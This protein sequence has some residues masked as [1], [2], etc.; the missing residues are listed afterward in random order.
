MLGK[1]NSILVGSVGRFVEVIGGFMEAIGGFVE[2]VDTLVYEIDVL[3]ARVGML[4]EAVDGL[5]SLG[6][7]LG[8]ERRKRVTKNAGVENDSAARV[9]GIGMVRNVTRKVVN[10]TREVVKASDVLVK[11]MGGLVS[12][13]GFYGRI[14]KIPPSE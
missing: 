14:M 9:D 11:V 2:V 8:D 1:E 4:V 7:E 13:R 3:G 5:G 12:E 10:V 6:G